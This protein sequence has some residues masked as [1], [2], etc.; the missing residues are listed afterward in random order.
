MTRSWKELAG[1]S[2]RPTQPTAAT[3]LNLVTVTSSWNCRFE[4]G[5]STL[6]I[7]IG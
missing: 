3:Y 2:A 7:T 6:P 1:K 4:L 5:S